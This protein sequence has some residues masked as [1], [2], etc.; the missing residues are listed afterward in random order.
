L[1]RKVVHLTTVHKP[2]DTRIYRKECSSLAERGYEVV[3]VAPAEAS[4]GQP[5]V[6]NAGVRLHPL[7]RP[8]N[9]VSRSTLTFASA[10][11][12]AIRERADVYHIHDPELIPLG[13]ILKCLRRRVIYD[14]HEDLPRQIM[15]KDWVATP[16]RRPLSVA[17]AVLEWIATRVMDLTVAATPAIAKRFPPEKTIVVQNYPLPQEL[18]SPIQ[19]PYES[20]PPIVVYVGGIE[21][22]RGA[23]Q[24]VNAVS[25]LNRRFAARLVLA[26]EFYPSAL[27]DELEQ[28]EGW[29]HVIDRG[30]L[31]RS[32]VRELLDEARI[33]LV[34][35]QDAP[36]HREAQPSKLFEY[37]SAG[38]PVIASDFPLW[39][40]LV[41]KTGSGV[42][43]DP[44]SPEAIADAMHYLLSHPIE[45]AAMGTRARA[46][47]EQQYNWPA[48]AKNLLQGYD[49]LLIAPR[50][51]AR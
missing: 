14:V 47:I 38:L 36:N 23:P 25:R 19:S 13:L 46:A 7:K 22:I 35:F 44:S 16:M 34:L 42:V 31:S 43:V 28:M 49:R 6:I 5:W 33:G 20:R 21:A 26:G 39:R 3:L 27:R 17:W 8:S 11:K 4:N 18:A 29:Q 32:Q 1:T 45:A 40:S 51:A 24:M 10:L 30:W 50:S 37:M 2:D 12:V 9:R 15:S 48:E 41:T